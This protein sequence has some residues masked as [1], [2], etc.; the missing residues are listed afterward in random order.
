MIE[1][2]DDK[3]CQMKIRVK[4]EIALN[5]SKLKLYQGKPVHYGEKIILQH[6]DS[7]EYLNCTK[8][9]ILGYKI[10]Y[11]STL[12]NWF[13]SSLHITIHPKFKSRQGGDFIHDG[14]VVIL[15]SSNSDYYLDIAPDID[16]YLNDF[17][18]NLE[19][20]RYTKD[21]SF[22]ERRS[23]KYPII[24]SNGSKT[25]WKLLLFKKHD[26][27]E[28]QICGFDLVRIHH[29]ELNGSICSGL[30]Y[31]AIYPEIYIRHYRGNNPL[32]KESMSAIWEIQ[33]FES[34]ILGS[35][36]QIEEM[37]DK[38]RN[39]GSN[40]SK[41]MDSGIQTV[42]GGEDEN[43]YQ[44]TSQRV[45]F[46]HFLSQ[47][48]MYA[49]K[50]GNSKKEF[51][52]LTSNFSDKPIRKNF[53]KFS[54]TPL[55][56]NLD[57]VLDNKTYMI[58][59]NISTVKISKYP[60]NRK[61]IQRRINKEKQKNL[62]KQKR[63]LPS[64]SSAFK[65]KNPY[66]DPKFLEGSLKDSE[67]NPVEKFRQKHEQ[68]K[69]N[70]FQFLP[71]NDNDLQ[72][73]NHVCILEKGTHSEH[74]FKFQKLSYLEIR[75]TLFARSA[76]P[77]TTFFISFFS[78]DRLSDL[79]PMR[80][81]QM[82]EVLGRLCCFIF[83]KPF[84]SSTNIFEFDGKPIP[85]RQRIMRELNFLDYF[86]QILSRPF[87]EGLFDIKALKA[88]MPITRILAM[89]YTTIKYIIRENRP[90]EL[91][92]S[93]WLNLFLEHSL[94]TKGRKDI[95]AEKTL[96][97]LIDNNRGILTQRIDRSTIN[98][99]IQLVSQD[100]V[101]K[102]INILRVIIICNKKPLTGNQGIIS[103]LLLED[104]DMRESL[105][106]Q[107]RMNQQKIEVKL[108]SNGDKWINFDKIR[109]DG[110]FSGGQA[111]SVFSY[112]VSFTYLLGDLCLKRNYLA[113]ECLKQIFTFAICF[114]VITSED[115]PY[116][117][118]ESFAYLFTSLW[119]DVAPLSKKKI[120]SQIKIWDSSSTQLHK[121]M[122][123]R[124]RT[125][126]DKIKNETIN[127]LRILEPNCLYE[128]SKTS[129]MLT[130]L[131]MLKTMIKCDLVT[132]EDVIL[133]FQ[134]LKTL[135]NSLVQ[136]LESQ[137]QNMVSL[138]SFNQRQLLNDTAILIC[139]MLK[140]IF[141]YE[142][143]LKSTMILDKLK[144]YLDSLGNEEYVKFTQYYSKLGF[145]SDDQGLALFFD[146]EVKDMQKFELQNMEIFNKIF[147]ESVQQDICFEICNNKDIIYLLTVL[148]IKAEELRLTHSAIDL[149]YL[150]YSQCILIKDTLISM[151]L[152][153]Q[154]GMED[155]MKIQRVAE[156]LNSLAESSSTWF[157]DGK[158]REY[159][160]MH[161]ILDQLFYML[162]NKNPGYLFKDANE[163]DDEACQIHEVFQDRI[164]CCFVTTSAYH[165]NIYR[166]TKILKS[167]VKVVDQEI[168]A[169]RD[170]KSPPEARELITKIY[171]ILSF[172]CRKNPT[173]KIYLL[174]Y[175]NE[176]FM[177]HFNN[178]KNSMGVIILLNHLIDQNEEIL[179]QEKFKFI[180]EEIFMKLREISK[181][182]ITQAFLIK[183]VSNLVSSTDNK[184]RS[185]RNK[186]LS[187][188][189]EMR[190]I[191]FQVSSSKRK[192]VA[193][194]KNL[195]RS[196]LISISKGKHTGIVAGAD[197]CFYL[198]Y[199]ELLT[200]CSGG[201]NSFSEN[202]SQSIVSLEE[203]SKIIN[204]FVPENIH[205]VIQL[206]M[207]NFFY[208]VYLETER[209]NF[210]H[211]SQILVLL[212][213]TLVN[214]FSHLLSNPLPSDIRDLYTI[215]HNY[216]EPNSYYERELILRCI[217]CFENIMKKNI[218]IKTTSSGF[219]SYVYLTHQLQ[220]LSDAY[221]NHPDLLIRQRLEELNG[222][223]TEN[224]SFEI[225][226]Y[227]TNL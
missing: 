116:S 135:L 149:L 140:L 71:L 172:C 99:F 22:H 104:S 98:K 100:K 113:I 93:Q 16:H 90:N 165:Q 152:V 220:Q 48:Y 118:R 112:V 89:T 114:E 214:N 58:L 33:S 147:K 164:D 24:F 168:V 202:M 115:Y 193:W 63:N 1:Y 159:D 209:D 131:K 199:L 141:F 83:G 15:E 221:S 50:N 75:D 23:K 31:R 225:V 223:V 110:S 154:K 191:D 64:I 47:R 44:V 129:F 7:E 69:G 125:N 210:F 121:N 130:M 30:N 171:F 145:S 56:S 148:S 9:H 92:C 134:I 157:H 106:Y 119:I 153:S 161:N 177:V 184:T 222:C 26:V 224:M 81:K 107:I 82:E 102:Y 8:K 65:P 72:E 4:K 54:L 13:C 109:S 36:I 80:Y 158:S 205:P 219:E 40:A 85:S 128:S 20:S 127:Y 132:Q 216:C 39:R 126:F 197:L 70:G 186:V 12:H 133:I 151:Q 198:A 73:T 155:F 162:A 226:R 86:C 76:L 28:R 62:N 163:Y 166:S 55:V 117:I 137:N 138:I 91:Y 97:E 11:K 227:I 196:E 190:E 87:S 123:Q 60:I 3:L 192:I 173:N 27:E 203:L 96:T 142:I 124:Q 189:Y 194:S 218:Q 32:E 38:M 88:N 169:S 105:L 181:N 51:I 180:I 74:A 17:D 57:R 144:L 18:I 122:T 67:L 43:F 176:P 21:I 187:K 2:L 195:W 215:T 188:I 213:R 206:T 103:K 167:L 45:K 37:D 179:S 29:T 108:E 41:M 94:K 111:D 208:E 201:K 79:K 25:E 53:L 42:R 175:L 211:F 52:M 66:L 207:I 150:L 217:D 77:F 68:N 139:Q 78:K 136:I 183:M 35:P 178:K 156:Q 95:M 49:T 174:K 120:P 160:R 204:I 59:S 185:T 14:E 200:K 34:G 46:K 170:Q 19:K 101:A 5:K 6:V 143:D 146:Y 212:A 84:R 61:Q 182:H 10:G